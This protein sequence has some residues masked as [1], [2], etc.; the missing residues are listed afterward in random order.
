[1]GKPSNNVAWGL[2]FG[3]SAVRLVCVTR[4]NSG[5]HADK[6]LET[7]LD[8]R[9]EKAADAPAAVEQMGAKKVNDPLVACV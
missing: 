8:E 2:E 6:F 4:S 7:P 5:Y 1:M 9:W 3:G